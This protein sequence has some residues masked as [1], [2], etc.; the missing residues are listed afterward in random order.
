[1]KD[2]HIGKLQG[3]PDEKSNEFTQA[4][5]AFRV[6]IDEESLQI[7]V[8]HNQTDGSMKSKVEPDPEK[9]AN[10]PHVYHAG[11]IRFQTYRWRAVLKSLKVTAA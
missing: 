5:I 8:A 11:R 4:E 9:I 10:M 1:V 7:R 6:K 2:V 3:F